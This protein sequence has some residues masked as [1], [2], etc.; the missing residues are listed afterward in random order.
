MELED[1][2][3]DPEIVEEQTNHGHGS[4]NRH[5]GQA[6]PA[7]ADLRLHGA[8]VETAGDGKESEEILNV[9]KLRKR[10]EGK[11]KVVLTGSE[12]EKSETGPLKS[13]DEIDGRKVKGQKGKQTDEVEDLCA[14]EMKHLKIGKGRLSNLE[15]ASKKRHRELYESDSDVMPSEPTVQPPQKRAKAIPPLINEVTS[16]QAWGKTET[17]TPEEGD[18]AVLQGQCT[19]DNVAEKRVG[20][21]PR[22]RRVGR[23]KKADSPVQEVAKAGGTFKEWMVS[24]SVLEKR[25][26]E[27]DE[28]EDIRRPPVKAARKRVKSSKRHDPDKVDPVLAAKSVKQSLEVTM[29][30]GCGG[31]RMLGS[32][33]KAQSKIV[34]RAVKLDKSSNEAETL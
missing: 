7:D 33:R 21:I 22:K 29:D 12:R 11:S 32:D 15:T 26:R 3:H 16:I 28:D 18:D 13:R 1:D 25:P 24:T 5:F 20:A 8:G 9:G 30:G 19:A 2:D 34:G 31:N 23:V 6:A 4:R 17:P 10:G 14:G 27:G